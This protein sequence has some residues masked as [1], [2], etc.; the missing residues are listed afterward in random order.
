MTEEENKSVE[1]VVPQGAAQTIESEEHN[2][3]SNES[4]EDKQSKR[5]DAD[6]NW[7]EM[8]RSREKDRE[9]MDAL[10]SEINLLKSPP[11][12]EEEDFGISDDDLV[13][14]KHLKDLKREIKKLKSDLNRKEISSVEERVQTK[15]SDYSDVVSK[16]NIELLKQKEPELAQSIYHIKD[17]YSQAVAAYKLI[18]NTIAGNNENSLEKRKAMENSQKPVSV[19]AITKQSAIGNAHLF[20]NG[21]TKDLKSQLWK[22]MQ[23][24]MKSG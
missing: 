8:R 1:E 16:D 4:Q 10:E 23:S 13:E 6:H 11:K 14:G 2:D 12:T 21:L 17:P 5:N 9:K 20:E 22:E 3:V 15:F 19:N 24:A 7:A 18:K